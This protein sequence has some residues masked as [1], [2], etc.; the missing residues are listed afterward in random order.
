LTLRKLAAAFLQSRALNLDV[1]LSLG[2]VIDI[3]CHRRLGAAEGDN[4]IRLG[5]PIA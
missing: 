4:R 3:L 1:S 2:Q 5:A